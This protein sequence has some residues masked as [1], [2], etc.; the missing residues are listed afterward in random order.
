ML[1]AVA[2]ARCR[3]FLPLAALLGLLTLAAPASALEVEGLF[4]NGYA[5][6]L[7]EPLPPPGGAGR[8][9]IHIA[10]EFTTPVPIDLSTATV[11]VEAVLNELGEGGAGE[12]TSRADGAP[13][14]P[15]ELVSNNSRRPFGGRFI[16]ASGARP[17]FL[18]DIDRRPRDGNRYLV[19]LKIDRIAIR[20]LPKLCP[21]LGQV[22]SLTE[23][24]TRFVIHDGQGEPAVFAETGL[25]RC[26]T[27][28]TLRLPRAGSGTRPPDGGGS[29]PT[30]PEA[31]L[32]VQIVNESAGLVRLDGSRSSDRDG[33]VTTWSF[34]VR[35]GFGLVVLGP[36]TGTA[37]SVNVTLAPG[38]Y[39]AHVG[40]TDNQGLTARTSRTF[41]LRGGS[42]VDGEPPRATLRATVGSGGAVRLDGSD[43]FDPDGVIVAWAFQITTRN[44]AVVAG[45]V[46]GSSPVLDQTLPSGEYYAVMVATDDD[47]LRDGETRSLSVR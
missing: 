18:L 4:D 41:S 17:Q 34:D 11:T 38:E 14:L 28:G 2:T 32:S 36:L 40:V 46:S 27:G 10:G 1:H 9:Q 42:G 26:G 45:P 13:L 7:G 20:F 23:I 16:S 6:R 3:G 31:S 44:G 37:S 29:D 30:P 8:G 24:E 22:D 12:L 39:S 15:L 33:A 47:G 5:T 25:W 35:D 21:H 43:S 19:R